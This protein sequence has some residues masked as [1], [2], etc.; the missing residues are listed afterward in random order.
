MVNTT[1]NHTKEFKPMKY[2]WI[3]IDAPRPAVHFKPIN[4]SGE[5]PAFKYQ[6][7]ASTRDSLKPQILATT[8]FDAVMKYRSN[9]VKEDDEL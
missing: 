3:D 9:L 5:T 1:M 4:E 2:T 7:G 8:L 6:Q